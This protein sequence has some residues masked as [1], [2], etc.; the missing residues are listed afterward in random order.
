MADAQVLYSSAFGATHTATGP[1]YTTALTI[2]SGSFTASTDYIILAWAYLW[3]N[4]A[5]SD[6][7]F[8]VQKGG[9][10]VTDGGA[11]Y[12]TTATSA[13]GQNPIIFMR[14]ITQGASPEAITLDLGSSSTNDVTADVFF[15]AFNCTDLGT[16]NTDW[17]WNEVTADYTTTSSYVSKASVTYSAN[18]TDKWLVFGDANFRGGSTT[19]SCYW[20]LNDSVVGDL[21][22]NDEEPEDLTNEIRQNLIMAALTPASGSHTLSAQFSHET[23]AG[24]IYSSRVFAMNLARFAQSAISRTAGTA[25]PATTTAWTTLETVAPT[26]SATGDWVILGSF[27]DDNNSLT[28]GNG[29]NTRLQ[30][31]ASGG[32]LVSNP[33]YGDD[34]PGMAGWDALD[35]IPFFIGTK[36]SLSSG[37]SR[38]INLDANNKT[39]TH[40]GALQRSLAAFSVALASAGGVTAN[41]GVVDI[42]VVLNAVTVTGDAS[43][44]TGLLDVNVAVN[45]VTATGGTTV[46]VGLLDVNVAV[47][48]V[49]VTG[50]ASITTGLLDVNLALNPVT[51]TG[52][53][54]TTVGLHDINLALLAV[55]SA[56][57]T[58]ET[59]NV[60]L[61]DVNLAING[62]TVTGDASVTA[63]L[64]D[65]NVVANAVT[66]TGDASVTAGLLDINLVANAVTATGDATTTTG[67]LDINL[68]VNAVTVDEGANPNVTVN[69]GLLNVLFALNS[70]TVVADA[71]VTVG[72]LDV[73]VTIN[74]VTVTGDAQAT[75]GLHTLTLSTFAVTVSASGGYTNLA[76]WTHGQADAFGGIPRLR[77]NAIRIDFDGTQTI[78]YLRLGEPL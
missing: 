45:A 42:N 38:T 74:A 22:I 41:A 43:V 77:I 19:T 60:G 20:K 72:L 44:T 34:A 65:V 10:N 11:V 67:F 32:G 24:T 54:T 75:L 13:N 62:V 52:D 23:N 37:A 55:D 31:N 70:V 7:Y 53:A 69:T 25:D 46:D 35:Q 33:A 39:S 73:N 76:G 63:G 2:A 29:L 57:Q 40:D 3:N 8:R 14:R 50:D 17:Y 6:A 30:V 51:V 18:G 49:T 64:L 66:V 58:S 56:G 5:T 16:E 12:E 4:N 48:A 61:L 9:V 1:A 26:P 47:N 28:S 59:V 27:I 21:G 71:L 15:M 78:E 36:V 68:A